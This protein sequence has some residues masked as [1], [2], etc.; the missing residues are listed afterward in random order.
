MVHIQPR[1][2]IFLID[3]LGL[4]GAERLLVTY[5][6]HFPTHRFEARVCACNVRDGNPIADDIR[7][8]TQV[9]VD[10]LPMRRLTDPRGLPRLLRYLREQRADLIHTQ[11]LSSNILGGMAGK[12]LGIPVVST[13]HMYD[14]PAK[15]TRSYWRRQLMWWVMRHC[16]DRVIAVSE[17]TRQHH[18]R[19]GRLAPDQVVTLYNGIDLSAFTPGLETSRQ[20]TRQALGIAPD[21]PLLITVAV[22]RPAKGIQYLLEAMPSILEAMPETRYLVVGSGDDEDRLKGLV[23]RYGLADR[24][25]FTGARRDVPVLLSASDLFVLPT[26]DEALPTVLAEAMAAQKPIVASGVGGVPEMVEHGR[27]GLLVPPADPSSLAHA[28]LRVLQNPDQAGAM[29]CAGR[30]TVEQRFNIQRQVRRLAD[31]YEQVLAERERR[32]GR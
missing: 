32:N 19:M 8:L 11:L 4:G 1:R 18:M 23:M 21:A 22:L 28:C 3:S 16:H 25:V 20:A 29:A 17:G 9:P 7:R 30:Q 27:N 15:R 12:L 10:M 6:Q 2:I 24:V 26:L 5:L 31:L 14:A 13:Q